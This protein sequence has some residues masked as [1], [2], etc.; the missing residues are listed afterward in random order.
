M[1]QCI[2]LFDLVFLF[3]LEKIPSGVASS[4]DISIL[5][6][7]CNL[8][9]VFHSGSTNLQ[10]YQQFSTHPHQHL[11][12]LVFLLIAIL[13]GVQWYLTVVLIF[14]SL[15][16]SDVEHI[17][18][19]WCPSVCL[20]KNVYSGPLP[21]FK[22]SCLFFW[23]WIVW[24]LGIFCMWSS[25]HIYCLQISSY[26]V[27]FLV[28]LIVFYAVQKLLVWPS[29]ICLFLLLFLLPKEVYFK[30]DIKEHTAYVCF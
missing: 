28:L 15:M 14:I 11:L 19:V 2:N 24:A 22:L 21:I 29:P 25:Y 6:F 10:S 1:L 13:T 3:S 4:Y 12:F 18:C 5:I 26:S 16:I 30:T 27:D 7:L 17:L 20:W 23:C 8:H 9:T